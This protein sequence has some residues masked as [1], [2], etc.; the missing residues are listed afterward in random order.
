[1]KTKKIYKNVKIGKNCEI[2]DFVIIGA[3]P[4]GKKNGELNTVIGGNAV[5][6][7]HTVIYAGNVIGDNFQTG[8]HVMIREENNIG[9]NVSIGTGTVLEHHVN[10]GNNVRTH[11]SCFIPEYT[12][13][14]DNSWLG[15]NVVITNAK[16]PASENSKNS[17]KGAVIKKKAKIGAGCTLLPAVVIGE[18]SLIGAGSVVTKDI[19][20]NAVAFG[21]PAKTYKKI[22]DIK[23]YK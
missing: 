23:D 12:V 6:R 9:S 19:E 21:N 18:N 20:D 7:S 2:G 4:K 16:Y 3:P 17:L 8:H 5:I 13:L 1:M 11:S 10:I 22:T 15:P 14:E